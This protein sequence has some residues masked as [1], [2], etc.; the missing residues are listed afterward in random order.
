MSFISRNILFI[1]PVLK[2]SR[3]TV[4]LLIMLDTLLLR[5][6]LHFT[7][8]HPTTLHSTSLHLSILHFLPFK[9]HPPT[10]HSTSLLFTQLHFTP[11]HY[12]CRNFTSSH[13]NFTQ[14]QFTTL[15]FSLTPL[16]L[17]IRTSKCLQSCMELVL[18]TLHEFH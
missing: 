1:M 7:T 5:P 17:C 2:L 3:R 11:L 9:L 15:S 14:L 10:L 16:F 18:W 13:L 12:T 8:L 6:S 4:Y